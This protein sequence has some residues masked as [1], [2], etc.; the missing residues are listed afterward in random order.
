MVNSNME[1]I[2]NLEKIIQNISDLKGSQKDFC[3][4]NPEKVPYEFEHTYKILRD[5]FNDPKDSRITQERKIKNI[6]LFYELDNRVYS[7]MK[8][9]PRSRF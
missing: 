4:I 9:K 5:Y 2:K 8:K 1:V 7:I 3:N 6:K